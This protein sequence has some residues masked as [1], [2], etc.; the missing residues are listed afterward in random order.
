MQ[1]FQARRDAWRAQS[2][3]L[4]RRRD[5]VLAAADRESGE[6]V[7]N[8]RAEVRRIVLKAR[9]DLLILNAQ[10]QAAV[11]TGETGSLELAAPEP[12]TSATT[13]TA[14]GAWRVLHEAR[15]ELDALSAEAGAFRA[16]LMQL[17][18]SAPN[19]A[20]AAATD[21]GPH[22]SDEDQ[23]HPHEMFLPEGPRSMRPPQTSRALE[24]P[25]P[26][27]TA[28]EARPSAPTAA[29]R[30]KRPI[31]ALVAA[32]TIAGTFAVVGTGMWIARTN[33]AAEAP[34]PAAGPPPTSVATTPGV[35]AEPKATPSAPGLSVHLEA[36]RPVWIRVTVDGHGTAGRV[37]QPGETEQLG[38]TK[39]ASIRAGDAGA[40][41]VS[42][43]KRPA[44]ALGKDGEVVTRAFAAEPAARPPAPSLPVPG[45]ATTPAPG[46]A[47]KP[48]LSPTLPVSETPSP[49]RDQL[50]ASAERWLDAYYARDRARLAAFASAP[51]KVS[52]ERTEQERLPP[53][54]AG[55]QRTLSDTNVQVAGFSAVLTAKIT[56]RSGDQPLARPEVVSFLSQIWI[57]RG[58]V[59]QLSEVRIVSAGALNRSFRR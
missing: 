14:P 37:Y 42:V 50:V 45:S 46:A 36:R 47:L 2:H 48:E 10:V 16:D 56:E 9:R 1:D 40:V 27:A 24:W 51:P 7:A 8:A 13:S 11:G 52:D 20:A 19:V 29:R 43:N 59:W 23:A 6:I 12:T 5:D 49:V 55:V 32:G 39:E 28:D 38:A 18:L 57:Q 31:T 22:P 3:E 58:G 54:L 21:G 26:P 34:A 25:P 33:R 41:F 53:G 44:T 17:Q 4:A 15:P 30:S 35:S